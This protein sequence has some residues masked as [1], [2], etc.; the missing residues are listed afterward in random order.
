MVLVAPAAIHGPR[1]QTPPGV[2]ALRTGRSQIGKDCRACEHHLTPALIYYTYVQYYTRCAGVLSRAVD[3]SK[4]CCFLACHRGPSRRR[5]K[6]RRRLMIVVLRCAVCCEDTQRRVGFSLQTLVT[7]SPTCG[8]VPGSLIPNFS[9]HLQGSRQ[10][11]PP[12]SAESLMHFHAP[13]PMKIRR[14]CGMLARPRRCT[15]VGDTLVRHARSRV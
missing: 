7:R 3:R 2:L 6:K 1:P 10:L 8:R 15:V 5:S 13:R 11:T 9:M 12:F 4:R 14:H